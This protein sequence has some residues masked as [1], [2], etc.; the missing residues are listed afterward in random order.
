METLNSLRLAVF[1]AVLCSPFLTPL[2]GAQ[3]PPEVARGY[4]P[5]AE[6][7]AD[8]ELKQAKAAYGQRV[9]EIE[10][11]VA[12]K[13]EAAL[14]KAQRQAQKSKGKQLKAA[15]AALL[16]AYDAAID[17]ARE[18]GDPR[19]ADLLLAEKRSFGGGGIQAAELDLDQFEDEELYKCVLGT[20]GRYARETRY[21]VANLAVPNRDLW[22]EAIQ[23]RVRGCLEPYKLN[24]RG[25][26]KLVVPADGVYTLDI[27]GRGT[28]FQI[29]GI[30]LKAGEVQLTKGIYEVQITTGMHGQPYLPD[31]YVRIFRNKDELELPLVNTGADIKKFLSGS[32]DDSPVVEVSGHRPERIDSD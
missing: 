21:P 32:I 11:A 30:I 22:S 5:K 13:I 14:E 10:Q 9:A 31:S 8:L 29:N 12:Q 26:A 25:D 7:R 23:A 18:I 2:A 24:Y 15:R 4:V 27:P 17:R 28:G 1:A 19:W 6:D 3:Q 16:E 20:Y